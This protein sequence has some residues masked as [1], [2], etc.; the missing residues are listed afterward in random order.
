MP[1][2]RV[3]T[4]HSQQN[5]TNM[6]HFQLSLQLS[7][8]PEITHSDEAFV[9]NA[10]PAQRLSPRTLRIACHPEKGDSSDF[11]ALSSSSQTSTPQLVPN[12]SILSSQARKPQ[13]LSITL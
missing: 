7:N 10:R 9:P 5:M 2:R 11:Y 1:R 4:Q 8:S 12:H 3:S 13:P 6:L